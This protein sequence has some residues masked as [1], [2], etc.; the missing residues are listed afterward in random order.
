MDWRRDP[1]LRRGQHRTREQDRGDDEHDE[2]GHDDGGEH[3]LVTHH[4]NHSTRQ[5]KTLPLLQNLKLPHTRLAG[6]AGS[7][8]LYSACKTTRPSN[9]LQSKRKRKALGEM[10]SN[11]QHFE[12]LSYSPPS[13]S[14]GSWNR[15]SRTKSA[16]V[17]EQLCLIQTRH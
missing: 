16:A 6:T 14:S 13:T 8:Q 1:Q 5:E 3:K 9:R 4:R 12:G 7:P 2:G 15:P 17:A 10:S 11:L